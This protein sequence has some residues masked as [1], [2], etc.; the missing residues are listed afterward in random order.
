[1]KNSTR[2]TMLII[3]LFASMGSIAARFYF[4]HAGEMAMGD[5]FTILGF[6]LLVLST[7]F[8]QSNQAGASD[9]DKPPC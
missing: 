1:M 2:R 4:R 9:G 6:C 5:I 3:I 8:R 7:F